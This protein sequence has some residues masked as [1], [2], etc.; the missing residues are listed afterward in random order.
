VNYEL[1]SEVGQSHQLLNYT[2][3][4]KCSITLILLRI[5]PEVLKKKKKEKKKLI[6]GDKI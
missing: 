6:G 5:W 3:K 4:T 1:T 2:M